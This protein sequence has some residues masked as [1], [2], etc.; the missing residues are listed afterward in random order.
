MSKKDKSSYHLYLRFSS[1][2]IQMGVTIFA[3]AYLG[4][5]LDTKYP[6]DKK[7][8]TIVLTLFSVTIAITSV[9]RQINK[10]NK[11]MDE[12]KNEEKKKP[13]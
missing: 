7:W 9:L 2:A 13:N 1:I 10:L 6:M 5:W 3:G 11:E 12:R 8:F 4:K